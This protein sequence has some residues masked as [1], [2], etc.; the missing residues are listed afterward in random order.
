MIKQIAATQSKS[1][2]GEIVEA[3]WWLQRWVSGSM[4]DSDW[5]ESWITKIK[6]IEDAFELLHLAVGNKQ[7]KGK[8]LWRYLNVST[9]YA[10]LLQ[11]TLVLQPTSDKYQSFTLTRKLAESLDLGRSG[12]VDVV[13]SCKPDSANVLFG[14]KDLE[15]SND[16]AVRDSLL[17]LLDWKHQQEVIV[18]V[19][20]PLPILELHVLGS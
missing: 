5:D 2:N 20:K 6:T 9:A 16:P 13:I 3:V 17:R 7:T 8:R 12:G 15:A 4:R 1:P 18:R 14:W 11:R 19:T 10:K